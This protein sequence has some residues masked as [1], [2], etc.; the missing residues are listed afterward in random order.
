[1]ALLLVDSLLASLTHPS[2]FKRRLAFIAFFASI[3]L[4]IQ[5]TISIR[6]TLAHP[7]ASIPST[8]TPTSFELEDAEAR[9]YRPAPPTA[10]QEKRYEELLELIVSR[11][12][13]FPG[14]VFQDKALKV[15]SAK[16]VG[17]TAV[18][19]HWKRKKGLDLVLRHI[20]RYPY[21]REVIIWNNRPGIDLK[22]SV[23]PPLARR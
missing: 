12:S 15:K 19:L 7:I 21:I 18:L 17:A 10:A 22:R 23:R 13:A 4:S 8:S 1:M 5:F 16:V 9:S 2:P 3:F 6:H 20:T 14:Y 11:T